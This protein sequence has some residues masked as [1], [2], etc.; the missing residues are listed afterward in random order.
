M[1]SQP[2]MGTLPRLPDRAAM[3]RAMLIETVAYVAF[4]I[5]ISLIPARP[6]GPGDRASTTSLLEGTPSLLMV[7]VISVR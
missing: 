3:E 2:S 1:M 7:A 5:A 6:S 4:C